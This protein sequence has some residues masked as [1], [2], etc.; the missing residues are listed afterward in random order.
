MRIER[1]EPQ[2]RR[3]S[4]NLRDSE[5]TEKKPEVDAT[6]GEVLDGVVR[7]I[8]PFGVFVDLPSLGQWVSGLL[9]G[10]ETGQPRGVNLKRNYKPGDTIRVEIIDVDERGRIRLSQRTVAEREERSEAGLISSRG[11]GGLQTAAPGGFTALAEAFRKAQAHK[12]E[13]PES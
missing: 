13:R 2:R 7:S 4:L 9:P 11:K 12:G 10:A 1:I 5:R 6:V 3:I 8:K